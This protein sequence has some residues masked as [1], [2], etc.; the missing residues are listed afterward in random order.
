M[1]LSGRERQRVAIV[2]ALFRA[3]EQAE[4][5]LL[6]EV[7]SSLDVMTEMKVLTLVNKVRKLRKLKSIWTAHRLSTI[8]DV[9]SI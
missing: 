2:R 5:L 4:V 8:I 6:D 7:T 9:D 1:T 3:S